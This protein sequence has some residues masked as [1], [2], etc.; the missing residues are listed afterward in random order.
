LTGKNSRSALEKT[1]NTSQFFFCRTGFW[2]SADSAHSHNRSSQQSGLEQVCHSILLRVR[3]SSA[4]F[5]QLCI[6]KPDFRTELFRDSPHPHTLQ[7]NVF[8]NYQNTKLF[9]VAEKSDSFLNL[10]FKNTKEWI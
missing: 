9:F 7:Y 1:G 10:K 2:L 5:L 8:V 3:S 4:Q 6:N